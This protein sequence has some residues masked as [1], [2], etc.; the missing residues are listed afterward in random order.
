MFLRIIILEDTRFNT[1]VIS[2]DWE[3]TMLLL[4]LMQIDIQ[5][6]VMILFF[7]LVNFQMLHDIFLSLAAKSNFPA[8]SYEEL[9]VFCE[10]VGLFENT[11]DFDEMRL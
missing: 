11:E 2:L 10:E 9:E 7:F 8:V 5:V 6:L 1:E 4:L 3:E